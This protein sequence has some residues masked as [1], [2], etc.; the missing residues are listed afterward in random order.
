MPVSQQSGFT[1]PMVQK[2]AQGRV[3]YSRNNSPRLIQDSVLQILMT[4]PG[5]RFWNPSFG[6]RIRKIQFEQAS[7]AF[8]PT[9]QNLILEAL[10]K[11]EPRV[12][13]KASDIAVT[14]GD[15]GVVNITLAYTIN[16]PDFTGSANKTKLTIQI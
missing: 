10:N 8:I 12:T 14:F 5:E 9:I 2:G 11:W 4:S 7:P 1:F 3:N 16:N 15:Q 13:L 6:C